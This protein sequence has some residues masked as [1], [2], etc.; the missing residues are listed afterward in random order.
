MNINTGMNSY[1]S[2]PIIEPKES[3]GNQLGWFTGVF[4]PT[5]LGIFGVVTFLRMGWVVGQ[6]GLYRLH[7]RW[8][9]YRK[10][11]GLL[12]SYLI[13]ILGNCCT[14]LTWSSLSAIATNGKMKGGGAYCTY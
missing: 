13:V 6:V 11:S 8:L 5:M 1:G 10:Q 2:L 4:V 12:L 14:I 7:K 3:A 9:T